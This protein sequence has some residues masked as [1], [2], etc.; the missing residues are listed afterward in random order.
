[1]LRKIVQIKHVGKFRDYS[2]YG[3]V[4]FQKLSLVFAPNGRGKSTLCAILR[5]LAEG[6]PELIMERATLDAA[7]ALVPK[8]KILVT[9][10]E[11]LF[12]DGRWG[13][14]DAPDLMI[15]DSTFIHENVFTGDVVS[16]QHRRG[17]LDVILGKQ[18]VELAERI[19]V[20]D[21]ERR[22]KDTEI[23][24][25]ELPLRADHGDI[26]LDDFLALPE[27]PAVDQKIEDAAK[28]VLMLERAA[29]LRGAGGFSRVP[30][31]RSLRGLRH[32][33]A[34]TVEGVADDAEKKLGEHIEKHGMSGGQAWL[35][36]GLRFIGE[37]NDCPFCDR[38]LG[39]LAIIQ[40]FRAC[41]SNAYLQLKTTIEE[42]NGKA[43][44]M[45]EDFDLADVQK[46][47]S[48]NQATRTF[49]V[50]AGLTVEDRTL[51]ITGEGRQLIEAY[52]EAVEDCLSLKAASPLDHIPLPEA[53]PL[54]VLGLRRVR[55]AWQDYNAW[56][57]DTN[58]AVDRFKTEL[59]DAALPSARALLSRLRAQKLRHTPEVA[60]RCNT[61]IR[62]R[63][64]RDAIVTGREAAKVELDEYNTTVMPVYMQRVNDRLDRYGVDFRICDLEKTLSG[65]SPNAKYQI[66]INRVPVGLNDP[67]EG[68]GPCFRNT[69][70]SGDRSALAFAFFMAQVEA[71]PTPAQLAVVLDDPFMSLDVFRLEQTA[72]QLKRLLRTVGQ[73]VVLSHSTDFLGRIHDG[74]REAGVTLRLLQLDR[75]VGG[76]TRIMPWDIAEETRSHYEVHFDKIKRFKTDGEGDPHDVILHV[77]Q[78]LEFDLRQRHGA[79]LTAASWLG[80]MISAIRDATAGSA[81]ADLQQHLD[82]LTDVNDYVNRYYHGPEASK[83]AD[84]PVI[85]ATELC[86]HIG[87]VLK[88]IHPPQV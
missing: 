4:D 87:L 83:I 11:R 19:R 20:A 88:F 9:G 70:S 68:G 80:N 8:V 77:R 58:Q 36:T 59:D 41:F 5:S 67:A 21:E 53:Y 33:L 37:S 86:A 65:G 40:A 7:E 73:L 84:H 34:R 32:L 52:F 74:Y 55:R 3:E 82:D 17:L 35:T 27:D 13:G 51:D 45:R 10:G 75:S 54:A 56:V 6:R 60:A 14:G 62:L 26:P 79:E 43:R 76:N 31:P 57:E 48:E 61:L 71:H 42:A 69:L 49:W 46:R 63:G 39:G 12:E 64:E 72:T 81:L 28:R 1:M 38:D 25:A 29:E 44:Q 85:D 47:V 15:F 16:A 24:E 18:G 66:E 78:T 2:T 23:R 30:L 50:G 22:A